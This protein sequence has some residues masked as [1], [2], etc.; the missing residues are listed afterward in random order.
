[1]TTSQGRFQH[2]ALGAG[3]VA[4]GAPLTPELEAQFLEQGATVGEAMSTPV[5]TDMR[6]GFRVGHTVPGIIDVDSEISQA[7]GG[8]HPV[9]SVLFSGAFGQVRVRSTQ[10]GRCRLVGPRG[11]D[12][13]ASMPPSA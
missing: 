10:A 3:R 6:V 11:R 12:R 4:L 2:P 1:M 13:R 8:L 9:T 5:L 7:S